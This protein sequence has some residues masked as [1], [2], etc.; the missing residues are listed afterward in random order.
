M[1]SIHVVMKRLLIQHN[2]NGF[3]SYY[4]FLVSI[5]LY[6]FTFFPFVL[7]SVCII[8][9]LNVKKK[10]HYHQ[11]KKT[12]QIGNVY[13]HMCVILII[14]AKLITKYTSLKYFYLL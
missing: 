12:N 10:Q 2:Y 4:T 7:C 13:L 1:R 11:L 3:S 5:L 9:L 8:H 14:H 6:F